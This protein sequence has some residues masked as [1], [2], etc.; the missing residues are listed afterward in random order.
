VNFLVFEAGNPNSIVSAVS[1]ARE[2]AR[3]V[4]DQLPAELWEE[5]NR[6]YLFL[7]SDEARLRYASSPA[8]FFGEVR[9]ASLLLTGLG[10]A[11]VMHGEGW[12]FIEVGRF[13]ERGDQTD[14]H[15]GR[16]ARRLS[17]ARPAA[18]RDRAAG[19]RVD[20]VLRSCSAWDAY[21]SIHGAT[22]D[23]LRV[24]A[25]LLLS[26]EFPRS[27]RFCAEELDAALRRIS[28]VAAGRFANAAEQRSGRFLA[29]LRFA[30]VE[31]LL[32]T[33]GLHAAST[34][35][36]SGSRRSRTRST[37]STPARP[38]TPSLRRSNSR[39]SS[40][41]SRPRSRCEARGRPPDA[42]PVRRARAGQLQRAAAAARCRGP[43]QDC[44]S[45]L[46]RVV[47]PVG[48]RHYTDL[49]GNHVS[50]FDLD[51][52]APKPR[53]RVSLARAHRVRG[54]GGDGCLPAFAREGVR[55]HGVVPRVPAGEPLRGPRPESWRLA[56]DAPPERDDLWAAAL[57]LMRVVH[58][59]LAYQPGTTTVQTRRARRSRLAAAGVPGLRARDDRALPGDRHP[60][61]LRERLL[62]N[63]PRE[64]LR[65]AQASHAWCEVYVPGDGW[66]GLDPTNDQPA[67]DRYV[68]VASAATTR[69]SRRSRGRY[70]GTAEQELDVEVSVERL[71][72]YASAEEHERH[73]HEDRQQHQPAVQHVA[74][75]A[76]HPHAAL[77]AIA[78]TMKLGRCRCSCSRP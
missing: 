47:P 51:R 15:P 19:G 6:L 44:E 49:H 77:L 68:K 3:T 28:G 57:K 33:H 27:V 61:A 13:I 29:E 37:T 2:N 23:A 48:C 18:P 66:R 21:K 56:L 54:A 64:L 1:Q 52:A 71:E 43:T 78:R 46:L 17:R 8:E 16:A 38:T 60:G 22:V 41:S 20:A 12:Q 24:V 5:L 7:R 32:E 31:D 58:G 72:G 35:S 76:R 62:Y 55:A 10:H 65:G 30:T 39:C 42:L 40:S 69:T 45:F 75:E 34:A 14:P 50:F 11:T 4:R 25:F 9:S 67:G 63:G 74:A 36:S 53:D 70:R 59:E 73:D 26:E